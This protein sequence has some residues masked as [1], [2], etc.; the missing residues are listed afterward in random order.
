M[1]WKEGREVQ[2]REVRGRRQV[3]AGFWIAMVQSEGRSV[4]WKDVCRCG[5]TRQAGAGACRRRPGG[6]NVAA[7]VGSWEQ[8]LEQKE[9]LMETSLASSDV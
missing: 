7:R 4:I 9:S 6:S 1:C 5:R 3:E 8:C 2:W